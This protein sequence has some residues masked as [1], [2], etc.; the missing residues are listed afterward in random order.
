ERFITYVQ[1]E[2]ATSNGSIKKLTP[3]DLGQ[4]ANDQSIIEIAKIKSTELLRSNDLTFN[5]DSSI[6]AEIRYQDLQK[7]INELLDNAF[8]FSAPG[9]VVNITSEAIDNTFHL[10]ITDQGRGM[11]DEQIANMGAFRQFERE[12]YEQQGVGLGLKIV[13]KIVEMYGGKLKISS[14]YKE[15]TTIHIQL[16]LNH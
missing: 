2:L 11:T 10:F 3:S 8:K 1:L 6:K 9:T 15:K 5:L 16:P 13:S 12:F 7:I 14:I 4:I